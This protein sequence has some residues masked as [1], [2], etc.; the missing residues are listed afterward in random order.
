MIA[1]WEWLRER[2]PRLYWIAAAASAVAFAMRFALGIPAVRIELARIFVGSTSALNLYTRLVQ[3]CVRFTRG[4]LFS[5]DGT[6]RSFLESYAFFIALAWAYT[7]VFFLLGWATGGSGTAGQFP[8]IARDYPLDGTRIAILLGFAVLGYFVWRAVKTRDIEN[9]AVVKAPHARRLLF[10][11][12]AFAVVFGALWWAQDRAFG[13]DQNA[14]LIMQIT[15]A[16]VAFLALYMSGLPEIGFLFAATASYGYAMGIPLLIG[17]PLTVAI[18]SLLAGPWPIWFSTVAIPVGMY[19]YYL[20]TPLEINLSDTHALVLGTLGFLPVAAVVFGTEINL[21]RQDQP[22]GRGIGIPLLYALVVLTVLALSAYSSTSQVQD[23]LAFA[24]IAFWLFMPLLNALFDYSSWSFTWFLMQ[25]LTNYLSG[26]ST[27]QEERSYLLKVLMDLLSTMGR[28][29]VVFGHIAANLA[30]TLLMLVAIYFCIP[31]VIEAINAVMHPVRPQYWL[32]SASI[33]GGVLARPYQGDGLWVAA[34]LYS[35]LVPSMLHLVIAVVAI[36]STAFQPGN[37]RQAW[38]VLME[39][40][41]P[42]NQLVSAIT[43]ATRYVTIAVAVALLALLIV[44]EVFLKYSPYVP[45][46]MTAVGAQAIQWSRAL[47]AN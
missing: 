19:V 12:L 31:F 23:G 32:D 4:L 6:K 24:A 10:A 17:V 7:V 44:G 18:A 36:L 13:L 22:K 9:P 42:G 46:L 14:K 15:M 1:I 39:D 27:V 21:P 41:P 26:A 25:H 35:T 40:N 3:A 28:V 29:M 34:V 43:V 5:K 38:N 45:E 8:I 2:D 30:Y 33:V 11:C 47:L 37:V 16:G 20:T